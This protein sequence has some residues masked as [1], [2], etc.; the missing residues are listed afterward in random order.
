MI[1]VLAGA[2][3]LFL[4]VLLAF[5][6]RAL[7]NAAKNPESAQQMVALKRAWTTGWKLGR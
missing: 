2:A 3:G 5:I 4:G 1:V 6:R 7:K